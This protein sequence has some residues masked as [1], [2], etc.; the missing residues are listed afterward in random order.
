MRGFQTG[1]GFGIIAGLCGWGYRVP[2]GAFLSRLGM[3]FAI[4]GL[5]ASVGLFWTGEK[6]RGAVGF[7]LLFLGLCLVVFS[8][9][10]Y[11]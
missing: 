7:L 1:G 2:E 6:E 11:I 8:E 5:I 3:G 4:A 9:G 10:S